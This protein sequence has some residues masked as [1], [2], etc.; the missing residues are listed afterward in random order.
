MPP[1]LGPAYT[2]R[3][4]GVYPKIAEKHHI[5]LMP[6]FLESVAGDARYN[7]PDRMHPNPEGYRRIV[8]TI[9]PYVLEIIKDEKG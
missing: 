2:A 3:F 4:A 9:Y 6:F 8:D 1:N 5:L 7:L